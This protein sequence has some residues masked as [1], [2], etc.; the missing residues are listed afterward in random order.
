MIKMRRRHILRYSVKWH[1][2]G[3]RKEGQQAEFQFS[4]KLK[5]SISTYHSVYRKDPSFIAGCEIKH[6]GKE[7]GME[8]HRYTKWSE[9]ALKRIARYCEW[10]HRIELIAPGTSFMRPVWCAETKAAFRLGRPTYLYRITFADRRQYIGIT[11][12]WISTRI[13]AH[14]F[15]G[16]ASE[17]FADYSKPPPACYELETAPRPITMPYKWTCIG[18]YSGRREAERAETTAIHNATRGRLLNKQKMPSENPPV[19]KMSLEKQYEL[20][21]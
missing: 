4:G 13:D 18:V 19:L 15:S 6:A 21:L 9:L 11:K 1:H 12:S 2:K 3:L 14:K 20:R 17:G 5:V 10:Q 7:W 8:F 16:S